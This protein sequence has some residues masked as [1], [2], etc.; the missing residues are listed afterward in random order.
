M[1]ATTCSSITSNAYSWIL[2]PYEWIIFEWD[3]KLKSNPPKIRFCNIIAFG[4]RSLSSKASIQTLQP[5][6]WC[7]LLELSPRKWK[8]GFSNP[9]RHRTGSDSSNDI[10]SA[11]HYGLIGFRILTRHRDGVTPFHDIPSR[12]NHRGDRGATTSPWRCE[13][14]WYTESGVNDIVCTLINVK[15]TYNKIGFFHHLVGRKIHNKNWIQI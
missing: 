13:L 14:P 6:R 9:R 4:F 7:C 12:L 1:Q 3:K 5:R 8:V 11:L 10:C 15:T 2:S